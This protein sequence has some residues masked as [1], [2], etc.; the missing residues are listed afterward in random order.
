MRK[1]PIRMI[2]LALAALASLTGGATAQSGPRLSVSAVASDVLE[3]TLTPT[4]VAH[5]HGIVLGGAGVLA[6]G[7]VVARIGYAEGTLAAD[8]AAT[9]AHD[10]VQGYALIGTRPIPGLEV[11]VGPMARAYVRGTSTERWV[12]W[13]V[14]MRYAAELGAPWLGAYGEVWGAVAGTVNT[15]EPF[16]AGR[17][18]TAGLRLR[19][20]VAHISVDYGIDE[21]RVA[22]QP[23][24]ETVQQFRVAVGLGGVEP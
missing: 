16:T 14:R 2:G 20:G 12:L 10:L 9:P 22:A 11:L 1:P 3:R 24:R 18:G 6:W 17:G 5:H 13:Q 8:S 21:S 4:G 19:L 7:P 15:P 23:R